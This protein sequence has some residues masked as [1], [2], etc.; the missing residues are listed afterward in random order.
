MGAFH[1]LEWGLLLS[2]RATPSI[3]APTS[4]P[5]LQLDF[6]TCAGPPPHSSLEFPTELGVQMRAQLSPAIDG[7]AHTGLTWA[8][9]SFV[10]SQPHLSPRICSQIHLQS[11]PSQAPNKS[12]PQLNSTNEQLY[13]QQQGQGQRQTIIGFQLASVR[14][15]LTSQSVSR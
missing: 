13:E 8:S 12:S 5:P 1:N 4:P 6:V 2:R 15:L 7:R 9:C 11:Q 10:S 14:A 3:G